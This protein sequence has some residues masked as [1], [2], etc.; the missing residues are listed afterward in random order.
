M[1]D[2]QDV[3]ILDLV[4]DRCGK[5]SRKRKSVGLGGHRVHPGLYPASKPVCVRLPRLTRTP[6]T[7]ERGSALSPGTSGPTDWPMVPHTCFSLSRTGRIGFTPSRCHHQRSRAPGVSH[8]RGAPHVIAPFGCHCNSTPSK[9]GC[10]AQARRA[11]LHSTRFRVRFFAK[12]NN[13]SHLFAALVA[14]QDRPGLVADHFV[15][16]GRAWVG[17][18][19][20]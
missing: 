19:R 2:T 16:C 15:D 1:S 12:L 17:S 20:T 9:A 14:V 8:L 6:H 13:G 3:S 18:K 10:V 11:D 5:W 4:P 7:Q